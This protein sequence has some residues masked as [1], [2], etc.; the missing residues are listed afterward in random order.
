M[1]D[2]YTSKSSFEMSQFHCADVCPPCVWAHDYRIGRLINTQGR[3]VII[4]IQQ[5]QTCRPFI[6]Y[7]KKQKV[8]QMAKWIIK[9]WTDHH[10]GRHGCFCPSV[11]EN[12]FILSDHDAEQ[13][14]SHLL[15]LSLSLQKNPNYFQYRISQ[16][17][18]KN[19]CLLTEFAVRYLK[20]KWDFEYCQ[21][22][23]EEGRPGGEET[24][25]PWSETRKE[26]YRTE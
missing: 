6:F 3:N 13:N 7:L 24:P 26:Y 9:L 21:T 15:K 23:L 1:T 4:M 25:A 17:Q 14:F 16:L 2:T 11:T 20:L 12:I 10:L 8:I 22:Y 18:R 5:N 19:N